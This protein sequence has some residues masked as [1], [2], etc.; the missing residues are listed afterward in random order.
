MPDGSDPSALC[1]LWLPWV[2]TLQV[3]INGDGSFIHWPWQGA[4]MDQPALDM[5][6]LE[7]VRRKWVS[8][9]NE[10]LKQATSKVP[11]MKG[12]KRNG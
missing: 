1:R 9:Q 10:E 7:T 11:K 4:F 2:G 5:E 6:I 8:L 3:L 12:L